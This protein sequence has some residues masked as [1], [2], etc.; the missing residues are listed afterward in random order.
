VSGIL[1]ALY[2]PRG[3]VR[4][5]A[6]VTQDLTE[7]R[8]TEEERERAL[9]AERRARA[10]VETSL[11]Q[12]HRAR[13]ATVAAL[14]A[15]DQVLADL[16]HDLLPPL[17]AIRGGANMIEV[18]LARPGSPNTDGLVRAAAILRGSAVRMAR[19]IGELKDVAR[20]RSGQGLRLDRRLTDLEPLARRRVGEHQ[21]T[22]QHHRI[23]LMTASASLVGTWDRA[24][25][26]RTLDDLLATA[27]EDS[28]A[29]GDV[30]VEVDGCAEFGEEIGDGVVVLDDQHAHGMPLSRRRPPSAGQ[31]SPGGAGST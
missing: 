24:R 23:R 25:L 1:T 6:A 21:W 4:G 17:T 27:I 29:G 11:E 19:W 10:E 16:A 5:F 18:W 3:G 2:D 26:E 30:E 15:R 9:A 7:R 22:T 13:E 8:A 31:R 14:A 20:I 28:P 12:E